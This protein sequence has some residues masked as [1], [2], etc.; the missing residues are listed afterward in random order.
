MPQEAIHHTNDKPLKTTFSKPDNAR[1]LSQNQLTSEPA[2]T[3][4]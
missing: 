2:H 4:D 1:A 3:V